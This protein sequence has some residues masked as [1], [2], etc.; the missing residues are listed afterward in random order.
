MRRAR[1][2]LASL[3]AAVPETAGS[4]D[5][6]IF[7]IVRTAGR[8]RTVT[9]GSTILRSDQLSYSRKSEDSIRVAGFE[10]APPASEAGTLGQAELYPVTTL[11]RPEGLEPFMEWLH[12]VLNAARLPLRHGRKLGIG[13]RWC[14]HSA[15]NR[16]AARFRRARY[17]CSRHVGDG[18]PAR[19]R[20]KVFNSA[21]ENGSAS[22]RGT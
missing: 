17:T 22:E 18:F 6:T 15:S 1:L 9:S 3:R 2:E 5:F 21:F 19:L 4:T 10:P 13:W 20:R 7:A 14:R 8:F 16:E 12:S 11:M